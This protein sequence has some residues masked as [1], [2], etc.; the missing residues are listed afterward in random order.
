MIRLRG[1]NVRIAGRS[2]DERSSA[3]QDG[4]IL[5]SGEY[6]NAAMPTIVDQLRRE[7]ENAYIKDFEGEITKHLTWLTFCE[8][9]MCKPYS[10]YSWAK[11]ASILS[12]PQLV[13]KRREFEKLLEENVRQI[14]R[15]KIASGQTKF[16]RWLP[17]PEQLVVKVSDDG[18]I[19]FS[20][21]ERDVN[22][23]FDAHGESLTV[24][25]SVIAALRKLLS[26][27]FSYVVNYPFI[28]QMDLL[29]HCFH[30]ICGMSKQVIVFESRTF[31]EIFDVKPTFRIVDDPVFGWSLV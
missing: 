29:P 5:I 14:L 12:L 17:S 25:F 18:V 13:G 24:Y 11:L 1:E 8:P 9:D 31:T 20:N 7:F 3:L 6:G 22:Y 26:L 28:V 27:D 2:G 4:L 19:D 10:G 23:L 15:V 30:F 21:G 16:S